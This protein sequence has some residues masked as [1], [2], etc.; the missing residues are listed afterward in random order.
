LGDDLKL[1]IE[2]G[3]ELVCTKIVRRRSWIME[4]EIRMDIFLLLEGLE[5]ELGS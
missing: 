2:S 4:K 1:A 3:R 5:S